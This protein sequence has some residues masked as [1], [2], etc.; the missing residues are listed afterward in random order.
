MSTEEEMPEVEMPKAR[1][2]PG[3]LWPDVEARVKAFVEAKAKTMQSIQK[4]MAAFDGKV[5]EEQRKLEQKCSAYEEKLQRTRNDFEG[6]VTKALNELAGRKEAAER[7]IQES[8]RMLDERSA[9]KCKELAERAWAFEEAVKPA[10][11]V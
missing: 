4:G 7:K 1:K 9:A 10:T 11:H 8:R 5:A 3:K 2:A 6:R